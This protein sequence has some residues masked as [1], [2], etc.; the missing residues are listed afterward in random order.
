MKGTPDTFREFK[1]KHETIWTQQE[2]SA[3]AIGDSGPLDRKTRELIKIGIALGANLQTATRRHVHL[4]LEHGATRE[5]V[6][7]AVLLGIN[8][9]G[10]P[11][12]MIGWKAATDQLAEYEGG[13]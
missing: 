12:T 7:H 3:K 11:A 9:I 2:A 4:A 13:D 6:E 10:F 1:A 8:T 5:E